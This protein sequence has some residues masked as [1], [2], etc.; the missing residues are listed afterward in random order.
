MAARLPR[1]GL[2]TSLFDRRSFPA[3]ADAE[4]LRQVM[5]EL[6]RVVSSLFLSG[7]MV[8]PRA[9]WLTPMLNNRLRS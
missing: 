5:D 4:R 2:F 9:T 6:V 1:G 3:S 7:L 8:N